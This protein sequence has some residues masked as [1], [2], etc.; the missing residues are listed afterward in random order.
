M[1]YTVVFEE[2][3][4]EGFIVSVPALP[5]CVTQADTHD[6]ARRN[7]RDAMD[8]YIDDCRAAG[9]PVPEEPS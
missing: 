2:T 3:S 5:G 6:Q 9:D 7:I 1:R 8:L 4:D